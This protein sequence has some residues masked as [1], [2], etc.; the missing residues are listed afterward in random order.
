MNVEAVSFKAF[1]K[2]KENIYKNIML[3]SKRARQIVD[4]RYMEME[5]LLN[6][7]DTEQLNEIDSD[8][9]GKPKS[10]A[11]AMD[12]LLDNDLEYSTFSDE[13]EENEE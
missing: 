5:T 13:N 2:N 11:L 8:I 3:V 12:E 4:Q 10:I 1:Y 6:I 7:E 9:I